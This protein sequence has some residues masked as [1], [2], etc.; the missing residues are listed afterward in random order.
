MFKAFYFSDETVTQKDFESQYFSKDKSRHS[1]LR[2]SRSYD[3]LDV[4]NDLK[5]TLMSG[6]KREA[7][8]DSSRR[9]VNHRKSHRSNSGSDTER[10]R[11]DNLES[12]MR[13]KLSDKSRYSS[14]SREKEAESEMD[15]K[16]S[17]KS[18][19][20]VSIKYFGLKNFSKL[21]FILKKKANFCRLVKKST[22][23]LVL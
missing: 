22:R 17:I 18:T 13:S 7:S 8:L 4:K 10:S 1:S 12:S 11:H 6:L 2:S 21:Y 3:D 9:N 14:R 5:H 19:D 20:F 23:P 16:K 15:L